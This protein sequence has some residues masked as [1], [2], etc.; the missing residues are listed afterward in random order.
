VE[1]GE[2][3]TRL[4]VWDGD[5]DVFHPEREQVAHYFRFQELK[6]GRRYRRGDTPRSG[7]SG[8]ALAVDWESVLPMRTNPRTA[9]RAPHSSIR[10]AQ[11]EFNRAYC[12]VLQL[13]ERAFGGTPEIV[14]A[15]IND[16]YGLKTRAQALMQMG[17][18]DGLATAGPTFEFVSPDKRHG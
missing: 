2:G 14:G 17:T 10:M 4:Q 1:Q 15:A 9:D 12:S 5:C 6:I 16:M 3:A 18:E 11:E 7:P 13:L 8:D